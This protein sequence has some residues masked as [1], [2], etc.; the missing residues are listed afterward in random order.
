MNTTVEILGFAHEPGWLPWAVQYFFLIGIS[1]MAFFLSLPG[2]LWQRAGWQALSR[3]A[4][5]AAL[6]CG[7]AAP[8]ALLADL[9]QPGRFLNFYLHTNFGSWMGWGAYFIPVYLGGLL[10]YAWS[11]LRANRAGLTLAALV[12]GVGA[13]LVLVYTG[14]ETMIVAARPLWHSFLIPV[15]FAITALAGA[16]GMTALFEVIAG[17]REGAAVL[18]GGLR[19]SQWAV[20]AVI[21]T[22][23]MMAMSGATAYR[24]A[25]ATIHGGWVAAWICFIASVVVTL[26]RARGQSLLVPALFALLGAWL[27]RWLVFMGGQSV[28]KL[29]STYSAQSLS[30]TPDSLLGI[31]GTAGLCLFI[32]IVLTSLVR[33]DDSAHA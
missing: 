27:A 20:L 14:M 25:L 29:G 26:W 23:L 3:R 12:A 2:L 8:V 19:L 22:W 7:L 24:E 6:V 18:N 17:R 30:L 16:L 9:H 28:P 13:V 5:L 33:W 4:L 32:Y 31:V 15:F 1:T 11:V 10:A 21:A